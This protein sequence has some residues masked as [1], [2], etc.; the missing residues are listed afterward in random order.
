MAKTRFF[1][2]LRYFTQD[3]F[4]SPDIPNSGLFMDNHLLIM[5]DSARD[6]A[7]IPFIINSGY[8]SKSHNIKV[9]GRDN[10]SHLKGLA[11]DIQTLGSRDRFIILKSLIEVGF[12]R[13]GIKGSF[14][15][16]DIDYD[17]DINVVWCYP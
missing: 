13:I 3:E 8:R 10:S 9:G 5:L 7:N 16:V 14:I 17:K 6:K 11:V 12:N 1:P 15:H 2:H 4:A